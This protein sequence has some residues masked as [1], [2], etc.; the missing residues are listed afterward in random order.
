MTYS[1]KNTVQKAPGNI[2]FPGDTARRQP[3][4]NWF[5]AKIIAQKWLKINIF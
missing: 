2:M 5:V 4:L 3:D 1:S